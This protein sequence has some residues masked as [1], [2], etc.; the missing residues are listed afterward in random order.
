MESSLPPESSLKWPYQG[1]WAREK[2]MANA[3]ILLIVTILI[4]AIALYWIHFRG[5][6]HSFA[7]NDYIKDDLLWWRDP[8]KEY[9]IGWPWWHGFL[10]RSW[11]Q[12][13][14]YWFG[15]SHRSRNG[16]C[17]WRLYAKFSG[18]LLANITQASIDEYSA[19]TI[20]RGHHQIRTSGITDIQSTTGS[21]HIR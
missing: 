19:N 12:Y 9:F 15:K 21:F 18:Y 4:I 1:W 17:V 14:W 6:N 3:A 7:I 20:K 11:T 16:R 10:R 8:W 2:L 13:R 5:F